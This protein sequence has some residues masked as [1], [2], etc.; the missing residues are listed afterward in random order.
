MMRNILLTTFFTLSISGVN[1]SDEC[2]RY[3]SDSGDVLVV[4]YDD[5]IIV[6]EGRL[7]TM[8][9]CGTGSGREC[10]WPIAETDEAF[11]FDTSGFQ[12][13]DAMGKTFNE[14]CNQ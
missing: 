1:A 13:I 3:V 2:N 11:E 5:R 10:A 9:S 6:A 12:T 8:G 4:D 14:D 7:F